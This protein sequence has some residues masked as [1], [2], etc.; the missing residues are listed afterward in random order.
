M[1]CRKRL[2]FK[3]VSPFIIACDL[4]TPTKTDML[5]LTY[6]TINGQQFKFKRMLA[7]GHL[8]RFQ[9]N[10]KVTFKMGHDM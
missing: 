7:W 9:L 5:S 3:K 6:H 1:A 2:A 10:F 4:L 8:R